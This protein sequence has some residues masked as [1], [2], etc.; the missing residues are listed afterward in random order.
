VSIEVLVLIYIFSVY[1]DAGIETHMCL[2]P[3]FTLT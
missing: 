2:R 3:S 1:E